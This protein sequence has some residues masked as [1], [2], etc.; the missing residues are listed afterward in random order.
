MCGNH[1]TP[2]HAASY[3]GHL[4]AASLLLSHGVD[5]NPLTPLYRESQYGCLGVVQI[6]L[7]HGAD[8]HIQAE[9]DLT[10]LQVTTSNRH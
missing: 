5:W 7:G 1:G 10:P 6:L 9:K 2:L 4:D 3:K 8:V